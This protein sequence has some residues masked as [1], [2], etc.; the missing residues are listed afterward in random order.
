[1]CIRDRHDTVAA[2][3][4]YLKALEITPVL[5][6]T[7]ANLIALYE[8]RGDIRQAS[9]W[10]QYA[11]RLL[12]KDPYY[13]YAQ[14][15]RDEDSGDY[16]KALDHYLRAISLHGGEHRF[17]FAIARIYF[18]LGE[19]HKADRELTLAAELSSNDEQQRYQDKLAALR[20]MRY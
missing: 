2:E 14:G 6:S 1:M 10:R 3:R 5:S 13:Q 12:R 15:R 7:V 4:Y 9:I 8:Q 20:H 19:L 17:H 16:E 11:G 18:N